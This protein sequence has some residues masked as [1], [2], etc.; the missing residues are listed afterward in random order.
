MSQSKASPMANGDVPGNATASDAARRKRPQA[1]I[2]RQLDQEPAWASASP[3]VTSPSTPTT[4]RSRSMP[5]VVRLRP[6]PHCRTP[7]LAYS[8]SVEPEP[9]FLNWQQDPYS[10][11]LAR[12][13]LPEARTATRVT[14][15][16][17]A[18]LVP[19]NPFDFF[20]EESAKK[21]PVRVRPRADARTGA[22][23]GDAARPGRDCRSS[24][25]RNA[26]DRRAARSTTSS[27]FNQ[28]FRSD[29]DYVIRMEP[30]VQ[31]PEETL[32]LGRGSCRDSAWLLV[33][34]SRHL[35]LA[36]RFVS[37]YLI[38]LVA[39]EKPLEGPEGPTATSPTCTP[40]PRSTSPA[41][42]GSGSIRRRACS[43]REG[44]IPLACTADPQTAAPITGSFTW[45]KA[46]IEDDKVE[47]EF[48]FE[49][50]VTRH[51]RNA[52]GDEAV[53]RPAVASDR[54]A[55]PQRSTATCAS[56]TSASRW[57]ASRR[58]FASTTATPRNGTP[59]PSGRESANR[60]GDLLKRLRDRFAPGGLLH[61]GQGKWYPGESLPRW[62]FGCYW[63][64]DGEPIWHDPQLIADGGRHLRLHRRRCGQVHHARSRRRSASIPKFA[65]A[66]LT[67]TPG[68]TCGRN[69]G[70][71]R[72]S[73]R[74]KS[75]L[76]DPE[77][78]AR[79]AQGL[80]AGTR[81][82]RR[83]RAAR[84]AKACRPRRLGERH[85]VPARRAP[86]PDPRRLADGL[87]PAARFAA[88]GS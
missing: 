82:G 25:P 1:D 49:M 54:C 5:H 46:G 57:A 23:S 10:N 44:H 42:A 65:I 59:P 37:G 45:D 14:V 86:V 4:D 18:D 15:D 73:I 64:R 41:P 87:P 85:V 3:S 28:R 69:G 56:G 13:R 81:Q 79:L 38:Q 9:H 66:G 67:R 19:I 29:V 2:G 31:T 55:R 84:A 30:G 60:A 12:A 7:V 88:V 33:Q 77:E 48:E 11:Y 35:G 68:T 43:P 21:I 58:S 36:A 70:C 62:A 39:D 26:A 52:A 40:G 17:V 76:D 27:A 47:E 80:R 16:L 53:H 78:R 6:A 24:S 71:R 22:V 8:L 20:V 75:R 61:F 50:S 74:S 72:T 51:P 32:T 83:L 34:L 63:R